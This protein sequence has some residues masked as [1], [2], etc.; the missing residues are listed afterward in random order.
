MSVFSTHADS[1][2]W[3]RVGVMA[4]L[5]M[6][7]GLS[8]MLIRPQSERNQTASG[9]DALGTPEVAPSGT[10]FPQPSPISW[11]ASVSRTLAG[12][13]GFEMKSV[14]A[15]GGIFYAY[16]QEGAAASISEGPMLIHGLWRGISCEYGTC[17]PEV[18]IERIEILP[19][20]LQ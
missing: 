10:V 14:S 12:G 1:F 7:F 11:E 18:D 9:L 19:I 15:P 5:L 8:V 4:A 13:L 20:E 2:S 16:L 17:A 3:R 6:I